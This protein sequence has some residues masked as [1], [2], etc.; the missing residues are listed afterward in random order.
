MHC[1]VV[2]VSRN[3]LTWS[4]T[5]S[6]KC[7]RSMLGYKLRMSKVHTVYWDWICLPASNSRKSLLP[8][9]TYDNCFRAGLKSKLQSGMLQ[10]EQTTHDSSSWSG[11]QPLDSCATWPATEECQH[12]L[13]KNLSRET[14]AILATKCLH[15]VLDGKSYLR[16]ILMTWRSQCRT[17][18]WWLWRLPPIVSMTPLAPKA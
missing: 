14:S 12:G 8:P 15:T 18:C 16:N 17:R 10:L 3:F 13:K 4:D 5:T 1:I 11:V 2:Y 9:M 6:R 7:E